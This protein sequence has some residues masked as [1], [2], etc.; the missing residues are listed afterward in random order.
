MIPTSLAVV[1]MVLGIGA[2]GLGAFLWAWRR[3]HFRHM[4]EQSRALF[5]PRD[6]LLER[7][8]ETGAQ[9]EERSRSYGALERSDPGE[10]GGAGRR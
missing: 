5:E 6:L 1:L 9:R 2:A 3:G 4:D 7:P 10:W 8:W